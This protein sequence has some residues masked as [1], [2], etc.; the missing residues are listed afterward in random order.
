[1]P[2]ILI[3]RADEVLELEFVLLVNDAPAMS[4]IR[5][6]TDPPPPNRSE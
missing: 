3:T 1:V 5:G 6:Q 4:G 2:A